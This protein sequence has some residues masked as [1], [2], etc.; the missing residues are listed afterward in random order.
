MDL[1]FRELLVYIED[2]F[3]TC[4]FLFCTPCFSFNLSICLG[5]GLLSIATLLIGFYRSS[6]SRKILFLLAYSNYL[7]E[8]SMLKHLLPHVTFPHYSYFPLL[9]ATLYLLT[10]LYLSYHSALVLLLLH[11]LLPLVQHS[12]SCKVLSLWF[13]SLDFFSLFI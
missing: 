11:V 5:N 2:D 12:P 1:F 7:R 13:V 3:K 6:S 9:L 8:W 10:A 4:S